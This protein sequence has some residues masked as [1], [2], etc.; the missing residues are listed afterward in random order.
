MLKKTLLI[1]L[2]LL[3]IF[4]WGFTSE[5]YI[6]SLAA[7][8]PNVSLTHI[9]LWKYLTVS[10]YPVASPDLKSAWIYKME[11]ISLLFFSSAYDPYLSQ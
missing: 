11:Q 1:F 4:P 8:D 9:C 7:E 10:L 2:L 6:H 3:I 5:A